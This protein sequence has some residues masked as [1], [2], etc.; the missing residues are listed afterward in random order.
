[1]ASATVTSIGFLIAVL[2]IGAA[3][4]TDYFVSAS[5]GND[6]FDGRKADPVGFSGP[7][8]TLK[9]LQSLTLRHGDKVLLKC[10]ER[11]AGPLN[12]ALSSTDGGEL[13]LASYG[14]CSNRPKPLITGKIPFLAKAN[15]QIQQIKDTG[16]IEQIYADDAA[17]DRARFPSQG[18]WI[19]PDGAQPLKTG[20]APF[21]PKIGRPLQG[22]KINARTEEW[23]I[24]ERNI[25]DTDGQFDAPLQY[26]LRPK[27]GFYLS[28]KSWMVGEKNAWA[29]DSTERQL[30]VR[31]PVDTV[32]SKVPPGNLIQASGSGS[33]TINSLQLEAAGG[34]AVNTRLDGIVS[35]KDVT[36]KR[37][38]GNG[39]AIAGAKNAFIVNSTIADVGLDAIFFAETKRVFVR[40]NH[41]SNAGMFGAPRP[42]LA[43]INAHRTDSATIEENI[44]EN[45]AYI[46][47]R[48]SGDARIRNNYV[49]QSCL[50]LSDCAGI[51]TWRRNPQDRRPFSEVVGNIVN[52][53]RGDTSIKL[54]V[55]DYFTG[56]YLDDFSNEILVANN[57]IVDVNQGI[58]L[59]NAYANEV[60]N[61]IVRARNVTI[62]DAADKV[63]YPS[64]AN[65]N[66]NTHSNSERLGS[67]RLSLFD[68][69]GRE[70]P[71]AFDKITN[72]EIRQMMNANASK[73]ANSLC[74]RDKVYQPQAANN[75]L[76]ESINTFSC[77]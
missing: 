65:T 47:I 54:G 76:I 16:P 26:P 59:H 60:K 45:S 73:A 30:T 2:Q 62:L 39:I 6:Q 31:A 10:G 57:I 25:R 52:G 14:D 50:T 40:R 55:N 61:N 5:D 9:P 42:S 36:I 72:I 69:T 44:V 13:L 23:F 20:L 67:H 70:V 7:F 1:M 15:G 32:L 53:A 51:Y 21:A 35:I 34:D 18:Y 46:G 33:L 71:F 56:I 64:L 11:F 37:A 28:G 38:T 19:I 66:N 8:A 17:L 75:G 3:N 68:A 4:A 43:A 24:E 63:K 48:F 12:I 58:Y 74:A 41:I 29:Y 22:A 27:N 77:D 49:A